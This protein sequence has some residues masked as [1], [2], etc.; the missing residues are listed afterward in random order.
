MLI[1]LKCIIKS[2]VLSSLFFSCSLFNRKMQNSDDSY[3]SSFSKAQGLIIARDYNNALTYIKRSLEENT[4]NYNE[5]LLLAARAYDQLS[6]P[7]QAILA[8]Q[9]FL[10]PNQDTSLMPLKELTAR[11][12]LLKNRSKVKWDITQDKEKTVLQKLANNK[13]YLKKEIL[14]SLSWSLDFSCDQYC[15][16]EILYFQEI[17]TL[18]LYIVEQDIYSSSS[19]ASLIKNR[20]VFFHNHLQSDLFNHEFKKQ[21][22]SKLY[23]CLQKL[24]NLDLVYTQENKIYPS[25]ELIASLEDL[26]K[27]LE[28]WHYK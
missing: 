6:Q 20:Y 26:E 24:K 7:E 25:Q 4:I 9:E 27:D 3:G 5:S 18:L 22:A 14:E 21:I 2:V 17:Q 15:V 19:A 13:N 1:Y 16:D 23:D 12:L 10:K 28:R 8:L 11:S